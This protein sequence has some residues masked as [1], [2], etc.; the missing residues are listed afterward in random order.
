[1]NFVPNIVW[2]NACLSYL[3]KSV[4][5]SRYLWSGEI[6]VDGKVRMEP[7]SGWCCIYRVKRMVLLSSSWADSRIVTVIPEGREMCAAVT[8]V[9]CQRIRFQA[10]ID[11]IL[12]S[13]L[14]VGTICVY[15]CIFIY[16]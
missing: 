11:E 1:M 4:C 7:Q 10:R 15:I 13:N 2:F 9:M 6:Y 8:R 5:Q 3:K 14:R 16:I 12:L